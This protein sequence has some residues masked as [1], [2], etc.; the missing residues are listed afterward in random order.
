MHRL[1]GPTQGYFVTPCPGLRKCVRGSISSGAGCVF[2]VVLAAGLWVALTCWKSGRLAGAFLATGITMNLVSPISWIH[3]L[4]YL[5]L[6]VAL[7]FRESLLR[8]AVWGW[9]ALI[10]FVLLAA[11]LPYVGNSLVSHHPRGAL[12][13][14]GA[15]LRE[16]YL[17]L[18]L[19]ALFLLQRVSPTLLVVP[20]ASQNPVV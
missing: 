6:T 2:A 16:S 9:A 1:P 3:H 4:V 17:V 19:F 12:H 14:L 8:S 20:K 11:R 15:V 5:T 18:N 10:I 13:L 7:S